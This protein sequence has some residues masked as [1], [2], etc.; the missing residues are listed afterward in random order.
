VAYIDAS[1]VRFAVVLTRVVVLLQKPT[2]IAFYQAAKTDS[3]NLPPNPKAFITPF[4][5]YL[6]KRQQ[7]HN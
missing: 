6:E 2:M 7:I 3:S 1:D 4:W 5:R